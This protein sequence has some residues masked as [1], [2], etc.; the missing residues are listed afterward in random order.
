MSKRTTSNVI[1]QLKKEI[2]KRSEVAIFSHVSPDG[3]CIGSMLALGTALEYLGKKVHYYN[4]GPL[5]EN[6]SFLPGIE[7][8]STSLC[9]ECPD[10]LFFIDCAEAERAHSTMTKEF[11]QGKNVINID[12]H[13]SNNFFGTI[14]WVDPEA[15][16]TGEMVYFLLKNLGISISKDIAINL[17]TAIITDTGR[18]SFSNTTVRSFKIAADLLTTG[19]D[20]VSINNMLF[21]QKTLAQTKL[22]QKALSNMEFHQDGT[23]AMIVLSKR[24]FEESG[25][26]E[27]LSE[28]LVNYARNIENVE[29]A[30]LLKEIDDTNIKVSFRSNSWIDVNAVAREFG[31]GGH[32]RASGCTINLSLADAKKTVVNALEEALNLGRDH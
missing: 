26:E 21:E 30:V 5:P 7:H 2:E 32:I 9:K 18:F 12:H 10:T 20:L 11:L 16:A 22:L 29:A 24:D 6:L 14:N 19:I 27:N 1:N 3:D 13:V 8:I 28:G 25:A 4:A 17:Y 15:G 31:G 23:I